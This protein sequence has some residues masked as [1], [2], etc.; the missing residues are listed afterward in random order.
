MHDGPAPGPGRRRGRPRRRRRRA[1]VLVHRHRERGRATSGAGPVFA[2]VDADTGNLTAETVDAALTPRTRAVIAVDQGGV[3]VDLD[4]IRAVV[5]PARDRRRRGR[6]VRRR[7]DLPRP[8]GGRGRRDRRVVVPP[9]QARSPPARAG[10][11]RRR[12]ADWAERARRLRE[13]A[14]SVSAAERHASVLAPAE[15]YVEV[16]FNYR[17]TDLQAA[18]GLVQLGRLD[19]IVARRREIAAR[20]QRGASRTCPACVRSATRPGAPPTSS[21][22]GSRSAPSYPLDRDGLLAAP[23]RGGDLRPARDH[24]RAP[25]AGVRRH[26][27]RSAAGHRAPH[28]HAR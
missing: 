25:A 17:M 12:G 14:M 1:V 21:R 27:H 15:E 23:G 26:R 4:A 3:P 11:S 20:Y 13:H 18:V 16:G 9:P 6:R 5:R 22:S 10:C 2:D 19:E 8:P 24:G 28:R 7:L